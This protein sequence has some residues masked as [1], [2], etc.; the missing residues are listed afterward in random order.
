MFPG[1]SCIMLAWFS[2]IEVAI[3][4]IDN[5]SLSPLLTSINTLKLQF[6][7][8]PVQIAGL[9]QLSPCHHHRLNSGRL[10]PKKAVQTADKVV[11]CTLTCCM[12]QAAFQQGTI[13]CGQHAEQYCSIAKIENIGC[14]HD[15]WVYWRV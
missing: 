3:A 15:A 6:F 1:I 12:P 9:F 7:P 14:Y 8:S 13:V 5:I 10:L 2:S 11:F 4:K